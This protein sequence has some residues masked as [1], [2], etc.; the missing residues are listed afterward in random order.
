MKGVFVIAQLEKY[1]QT[2]MVYYLKHNLREYGGRIT[3]P[4]N[5]DI[6]PAMSQYNYILTPETHGR[7]SKEIKAYYSSR[8]QEIYLYDRKDVKPCCSWVVTVPGDLPEEEL[9]EF[10]QA[11]Y[12]YTCNLYGEKNILLAA[13][14]MDEGVKDAKGNHIAG[15]P[16]MHVIFMPV[17]E[18][19]K[20]MQPNKK[21]IITKQNH[22][23]E[24]ISADALLN[25]S[26]LKKF[27]PN[28]QKYLNSCGIHGT[29][30][31]GVTGGMNRTVDELKK[32]TKEELIRKEIAKEY[33]A[34]IEQIHAE[35]IKIINTIMHEND[36]LQMKNESLQREID[37]L[38]KKILALEKQVSHPVEQ[39]SR[40]GSEHGWGTDARERSHEHEQ[41]Y[42]K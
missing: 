10:F 41:E 9:R 19:K 31:S 24:K 8:L 15:R 6:D 29:V 28:F 12:S 37:T 30:Y 1:T 11:T 26:H 39:K 5:V 38:N 21:G 7:T 18:N 32:E 35:D 42:E 13:V 14:H 40:W 17:V 16:H 3:P 34:K 23:K 36:L 33:D 25:K 20:Y 2:Q 27:H 4:N 22:F